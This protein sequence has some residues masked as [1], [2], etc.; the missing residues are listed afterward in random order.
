MTTVPQAR[1]IDSR[2]RQVVQDHGRLGADLMELSESADLYD[3]GM[4]SHASVNL[5]LALENEFDVEFPDELLT[6]SVFSSIESIRRALLGLVP[7][8]ASQNGSE[9]PT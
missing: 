7:G 2:I 9:G 6:R 5:M 4:T 1:S 3:A 8:D